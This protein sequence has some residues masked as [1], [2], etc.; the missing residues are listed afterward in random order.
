MLLSVR[1]SVA[2]VANNSRTQRPSVSRFGSKVPHLGCDSHTS[3]R[4]KRSKVKVTRPI[5]ADTH[6]APYLPNGK[7]YELLIRI[8]MED[9]DPH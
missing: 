2:Y 7:A 6:H 3:F 8:R 5:N 9:D 4:V 1:L